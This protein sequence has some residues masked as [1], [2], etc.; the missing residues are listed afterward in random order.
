MTMQDCNYSYLLPLKLQDARGTLWATTFD[1]GGIHLL[2]KTA[3][4]LYALQNNG[5]TTETASSV[6]KRALSCYYS[7]T[8]LVS[9]ETYNSEMKMKVTVNKVAPV[10]FKVEFHA[11]LA[12]IAYLSTKS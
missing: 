3:K 1:E 10:D 5:T 7:F 9:T 6:I 2:H 12:K 11:L 8:L 4:Q